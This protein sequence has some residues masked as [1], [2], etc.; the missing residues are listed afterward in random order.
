MAAADPL[1]WTPTWRSAFLGRRP[2]GSALAAGEA[3]VVRAHFP[4]ADAGMR[5]ALDGINLLDSAWI[6]GRRGTELDGHLAIADVHEVLR[7][8]RTRTRCREHRS[9]RRSTIM[10]RPSHHFARRFELKGVDA[11]R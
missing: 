1:I 8:L 7:L 2:R 4:E 9:S 6:R 5:A 3:R 11:R 10:V